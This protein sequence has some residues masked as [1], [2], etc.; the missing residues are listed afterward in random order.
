MG[1][2]LSCDQCPVLQ[3]RCFEP[4][5]QEDTLAYPLSAL[6]TTSDGETNAKGQWT[7]CDAHLTY[8]HLPSKVVH[9]ND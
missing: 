8:P 3:P 4:W 2:D 1:G 7:L 5:S 6:L 9:S